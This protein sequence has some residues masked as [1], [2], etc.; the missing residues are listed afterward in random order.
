MEYTLA[1]AAQATG[2]AKTTI[3]RAIKS[4]KLSARRLDDKT[5]RIDASELARVY[6]IVALERSMETPRN[7][8]QR[9][10]KAATT[11]VSEAELAVLRAKLDMME[12]QLVRERDTVED[13]R[14]RLDDEQAE[15]RNLQRQ[16]MPPVSEGQREPA[17]ASPEMDTLRK[18]LEQAEE[19]LLA[20]SAQPRP[21]GGFL[22][23]LFGRT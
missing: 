6:P 20:L 5:F 4:G 9:K 1:G 14:K 13:L 18:R 16:L 10:E 23:R 22:S 15:R 12:A 21:S 11:R 17:Q 19:R 2:I 3:F 8:P 7:V